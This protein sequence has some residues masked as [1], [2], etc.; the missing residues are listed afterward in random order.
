MPPGNVEDNCFAD[1]TFTPCFSHFCDICYEKKG[2]KRE[3]LD[4]EMILHLFK[5]KSFL[6]EPA[7]IIGFDLSKEFSVKE[8]IC[9]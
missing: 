9:P 5:M 7:K 3:E 2:R 4:L 8:R 1:L 6:R